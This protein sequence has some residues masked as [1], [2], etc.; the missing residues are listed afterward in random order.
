MSRFATK[1]HIFLR[2][3]ALLAALLLC[4][5]LVAPAVAADTPYSGRIGTLNW[6]VESGLLTI[7]GTG[8]IPD[9]TEHNP[10]PWSGHSNIIS[11][12]TL[13]NGIT[14][15]GAMAF[16]DHKLIKSVSLPHTVNT[17]GTMAFAG[18]EGLTTVVMPKVTHIESYAFSRCKSLDGVVLPESLKT[19]GDH[20]FYWC[21]SLSYIRIP[22]LVTELGRTVFG[23]CSALLRADIAAPVAQLPE[24]FFYGCD[25]LVSVTL[26]KEMSGIGDDAF[27]RCQSLNRL[28]YTGD[29]E[30]LDTLI[31]DIAQ[32]VPGFSVGN[33]ASD[34]NVQPPATGKDVVT[35]GDEMKVT[36]IE[37][38]TDTDLVVRVEQTTTYPV[39]GD[40]T[41]ELIPDEIDTTIHATITGGDGWDNVIDVIK[42]EELEHSTF[43]GDYGDQS[44][45][46]VQ[47][48]LQQNSPLSGD[49]LSQLAGHKAT[50]T[51]TTPDGS[52]WSFDCQ[53]LAGQEFEKSYNLTYSLMRYDDLSDEHKAVVGS[54]PCWWVYFNSV[55][56]FPV[57]VEIFLDPLAARQNATLY[58]SVKN[59]GLNKLQAAMIDYEGYVSF[60]LGNIN[61]AVRYLLAM[62]VSGTSA[63]EVVIPDSMMG[64]PD[65]L[66]DLVPLDERYT[67]TEPRGLL[68]MTM[69]EFTR[70]TLTVVGVFAAIVGILVLFF[71]INGKRKAKIATIR[72]QVMG[73]DALEEY[74]A[75]Q[76]EKK[77]PKKR[78]N[79]FKKDQK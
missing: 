73:T 77:S 36:D 42:K 53:H 40:G 57:T 51:I 17:V 78:N 72:A 31:E 39:V 37:I 60:T 18:C 35:E 6:S 64:N 2:L 61:T 67:L 45:V 59:E 25:R 75:A 20:A 63:E 21:L 68:G 26:P 5:L 3:T 33:V 70:L 44:P 38:S 7:S 29:S 1:L 14:R 65:D 74:D 11:R 34:S 69:K 79:P 24:W 66:I 50:V 16:Y 19:L 47:I 22:A 27:T 8:A 55:V 56:S 30:K 28:Y 10:A 15:I 58:E 76:K 49:W 32:S 9:Y 43:E 46:D 52:R 23:Y 4:A 48:T 62:N 12:V 41:T 71:I 54:A 13:G